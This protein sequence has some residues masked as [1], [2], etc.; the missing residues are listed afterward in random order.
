MV[1]QALLGFDMRMT[2]L[3]RMDDRSAE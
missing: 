2:P 1:G 3:L